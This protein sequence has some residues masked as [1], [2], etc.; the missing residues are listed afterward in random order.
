M[1]CKKEGILY[2]RFRLKSASSTTESYRNQLT[3]I[4]KEKK[5]SVT[6]SEKQKE[7]PAVGSGEE[8]NNDVD[9]DGDSDTSSE[10]SLMMDEK[11]SKPD[12][13]E[14]IPLLLEGGEDAGSIRESENRTKWYVGYRELNC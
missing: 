8:Q 9:D 6:P 10:G 4:R 2:V 12:R 1:R 3:K 14:M 13:P 5:E 7:D 11:P